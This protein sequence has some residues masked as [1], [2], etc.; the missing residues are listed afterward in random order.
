MRRV[1]WVWRRVS[2][3]IGIH[4]YP[5]ALTVS[6]SPADQAAYTGANQVNQIAETWLGD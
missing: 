2:N 6:H 3:V 1:L 4:F 5:F